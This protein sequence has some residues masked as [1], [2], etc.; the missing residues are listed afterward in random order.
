MPGTTHPPHH[1]PP[2]H[3]PRRRRPWTDH[4]RQGL[5]GL[6]LAITAGAS[7]AG[8]DTLLT[9]PTDDGVWTRLASTDAPSARSMPV[10]AALRGS[11]YLFGGVHDDFGT[12]RNDFLNDLYRYDV[13]AN[14]WTRL[15][16]AGDTPSPRAFSGGVAVPHRG[17]VVVFG[18]ARYS[19]DLSEFTPLGDVWA[20][21]T[22]AG[23]WQALAGVATAAA[24]PAPSP[25]AWPT[26]WRAADQLYVF[27]GV[28]AGFRTLNDLWRFDFASRAWTQ[29]SAHGAAG[30]PPPRYSGAVTGEPYRGQVTLYGGEA[31][32]DQGGF[33]F[34]R[35]TWTLD[36]RT[37]AWR[38]I[39]LAAGQDID[40]PQNH[41]ADALLG[42]GLLLAGGDQ[43]GGTT[44]CGAAFNQNPTNAL[45]RFDLRAPA[46]QRLAPQGDTFPRL[47]RTSAAT[48]MG[49][50][51][52]FSGFDFTC[53]GGAGGQAWNT[54]VYRYT[55]PY[56]YWGQ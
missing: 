46:W 36:L 51:Y 31:T 14:R 42:S 53:E 48:V 55:P 5:L 35:D 25:R 41:G 54:D 37:L 49:E 26:V 3:A 45:W 11:I 44:G 22:R 21:D 20:Y 24:G 33:T 39:P 12:G 15:A 32:T 1:T 7:A 10:T 9:R 30:S 34:L 4:L 17:W 19:A 38:Q 8:S 6:A 23:Q 52:V 2:T 16:P 18:G 56:R 27:G 13:Y 40:P 43:P 50:M 28:E 47:K 29:L